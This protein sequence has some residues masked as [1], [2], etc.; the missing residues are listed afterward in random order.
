MKPVTEP[1]NSSRAPIRS[2]SQPVIGIATALAM[3]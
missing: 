3:M 2:L 1:M